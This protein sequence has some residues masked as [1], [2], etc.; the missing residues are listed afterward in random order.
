MATVCSPAS[1]RITAAL[2]QVAKHYAAESVTCPPR[3]G[4]RKGVVEKANHS[5]T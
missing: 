2:A 1:G 3:R 4:N 5:A